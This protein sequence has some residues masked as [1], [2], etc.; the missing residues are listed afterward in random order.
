MR[1]LIAICLKAGKTKVKVVTAILVVL[2]AL[3]DWAV[4][5]TV[6]LAPVYILP[7]M[8]GAVVLGP[9]ETAALA[10][11][12]SFLR[13]WFDTPASQTEVILR[14]VFAFLGYFTSALFVT[15]LVR[16]RELEI[17]HLSKIQREQQLRRE[18]E[19]QL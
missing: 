1:T 4:G 7:M 3:G 12:G 15:A 6:S 18:A 5:S 19:E 17:L 16:N 11:I 10:L 13:A 2:V 8:L 14:F 9:L